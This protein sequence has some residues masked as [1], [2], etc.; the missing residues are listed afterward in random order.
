MSPVNAPPEQRPDM[1]EMRNRTTIENKLAVVQGRINA[2]A[3][4]PV[5][6]IDGSQ[7]PVYLGEGFGEGYTGNN[8]GHHPD[9]NFTAVGV[10]GC[11]GSRGPVTDSSQIQ[12]TD[13]LRKKYNF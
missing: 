8:I 1:L 10:G 2:A 7:G 13:E 3:A 4:Q 12:V 11:S 6:S 5:Y 9:A